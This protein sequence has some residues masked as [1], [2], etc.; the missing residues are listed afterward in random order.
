MK[1]CPKC[2]KQCTDEMMFCPVCGQKT[3]N[4]LDENTEVSEKDNVR[5]CTKCGAEIKGKVAFCSQCGT[6]IDGALNEIST[7]STEI[8][9]PTDDEVHKWEFIYGTFSDGAYNL[10]RHITQI[11]AKGTTLSVE[12]RKFFLFFKYGESVDQFDVEDITAIVQEKKISFS[13][14][15]DIILGIICLIGGFLFG[16]ILLVGIGIWTL[17]DNNMLIQHKRGGVRIRE[18]KEYEQDRESFLAFIR[19]YNPDCIRTFIS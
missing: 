9:K 4:T 5:Y 7:I 12:Q 16:T 8:N 14:V 18:S 19:Q 13:G 11:T 3:V 2:K 10:G 6:P 1:Q 15:L 17:K